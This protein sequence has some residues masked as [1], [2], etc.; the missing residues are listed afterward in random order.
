MT[1][2]TGNRRSTST[3]TEGD[4]K[5]ALDRLKEQDENLAA[6]AG[7]V[8]D[9]LTWGE[10]PDRITLAGLQEWLWYVVP[11]KY[12]TDEEGYMGRLAAT[13]AELFDELGLHWYAEVCRSEATA[14]VHAAFDRSDREGREAMAKAM[15]ASGVEPPDLDDFAWGSVMGMEEATARSAV[16]Y[17]L[18]QAIESGQLVVGG[19]AWRRTQRKVT[20]QVLDG[21]HPEQPGQT[22]RTA[23]TTERISQWVD[24]AAHRSKVGARL[25]STVANRVLNPIDPPVAV[26]EMV[27]PIR[28]F[29]D[30]FGDEQPL[31]LAG[32]LRPAFVRD[33]HAEAPWDDPMP[34]P[35]SAEPPRSEVDDYLIHCV[36]AWLQDA[37]ALRKRGRRLMRTKRGAGMAKDPVVAWQVLVE[38]M[39]TSE[40]Q[41]FVMEM[42]AMALIESGGELA[43]DELVAQ[44][45]G[46]ARE[47]G[48]YST[49]REKQAVSDRETI[50]AFY[51]VLPVL[52][53]CGVLVE[54]GTWSNRRVTLTE[55]GQATMLAA[56]RVIAA[57]PRDRLW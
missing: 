5:E 46:V 10:G 18:E 29:L 32:Y 7:H 2:T 43:I 56:L 25:R 15:D 28:W 8:Y 33:V 24:G 38:R 40:W 1:E 3:L 12:L 23:V 53:I 45:T 31:T 57:G 20:A 37:G 50:R 6:E 49:D 35:A 22:W 16:Q 9:S 39:A 27:E 21:D 47:F 14:R 30:R 41:R 42:A 44:V 11:T 34:L 4:V 52:R 54:N 36:R 17:G 19:R 51:D 26:A 48:W 55:G 13:A